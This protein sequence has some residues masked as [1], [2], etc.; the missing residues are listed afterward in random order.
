MSS[1]LD[2]V[3]QA[4]PRATVYGAMKGSPV[5]IGKYFREINPASNSTKYDWK[6]GNR[7]I[8]FVVASPDKTIFNDYRSAYLRFNLA[9]VSAVLAEGENQSAFNNHFKISEPVSNIIERIVIKMNGTVVE[10]ISNFDRLT[11]F[12]KRKLLTRD[13]K[14]A[15]T[16]EGYDYIRQ[17]PSG[18]YPVIA[19]NAN[20]T[21]ALAVNEG[22]GDALGYIT[23]TN[24]TGATRLC[25]KLDLSGI[26]NSQQ[27]L[28]GYYSPLEIDLYLQDPRIAVQAGSSRSATDSVCDN[29]TIEEPRLCIDQ[30][31]MSPEYVSAFE[32]ALLANSSAQ[33]IQIPF[34]T[35]YTYVQRIKGDATYWI[36]KPVR[37]LKAIYWGAIQSDAVSQYDS[38]AFCRATSDKTG[39]HRGQS[40][41]NV[42]T[43]SASTFQA[44]ATNQEFAG[45]INKWKVSIGTKSY[46]E[47]DDNPGNLKATGGPP[48]CNES[49]VFFAKSVGHYNDYSTETAEYSAEERVKHCQNQGIDLEFAPDNDVLAS[50][51]TLNSNDVR[52]QLTVKPSE[53]QS[54]NAAI[55]DAAEFDVYTFLQYQASIALF[56]GNETRLLVT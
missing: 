52:L 16:R 26:M 5:F 54:N 41:L 3:E 39:T 33:G 4:V 44:G 13:Q 34:T 30:I 55:A 20:A 38:Y 10:D 19:A 36:R 46:R 31:V 11:S 7:K 17:T 9:E 37:Y 25:A 43:G 6:T 32:A 45:A 35:Y 51:T 2:H 24:V 27:L 50:E 18:S 48:N 53:Q 28:S 15:R 8:T 40:K 23:Q 49:D 42:T 22:A 14:N 1:I 56:P 29:Y 47:I 12:F 21:A